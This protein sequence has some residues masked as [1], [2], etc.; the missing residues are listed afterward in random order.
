MSQGSFKPSEFF[1]DLDDVYKM[2]K[3]RAELSVLSRSL[4]EIG[5]SI[6][7]ADERKAEAEKA[8]Q[9]VL[10]RISAVNADL[11]DLAFGDAPRID[12]FLYG[13]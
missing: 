4:S 6:R 2:R 1:K 5:E 13:G 7:A 3:A 8:R 11:T 10:K 12:P 9:Q